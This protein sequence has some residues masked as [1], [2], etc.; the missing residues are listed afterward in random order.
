M[1]FPID[2]VHLLNRKK[3]NIMYNTLVVL[4]VHW[5][6]LRARIKIISVDISNTML[7]VDY[8]LDNIYLQVVYFTACI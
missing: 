2:L 1:T 7:K 8:F 4:S 6:H 3:P 5:K